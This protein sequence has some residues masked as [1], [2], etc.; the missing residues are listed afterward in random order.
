MIAA[1]RTRVKA[2]KDSNWD[3]L[4][5]VTCNGTCK[6]ILILSADDLHELKWWVDAAF[7][8]HPDF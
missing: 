5:C 1:L 4:V 7:V 8:V 3:K 2:P 6:D